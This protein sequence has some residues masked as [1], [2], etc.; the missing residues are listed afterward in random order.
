MRRAGD[1][2]QAPTGWI[3]RSAPRVED[4]RLLRGEGR[5]VDDLA[6]AGGLHLDFTRSAQAGLALA[7]LDIEEARA[8]PGV[9]AILTA[10][11]LGELPS[12]SVNALL[13]GLAAPRFEALAATTL[14]YVGQPVAAVVADS[15][16][17]AREAAQSVRILAGAPTPPDDGPVFSH[18]IIAGDVEPAFAAAAHVARASTR[19]ARLAPA[20]LEPRAALA[21]WCEA[22]GLT[23]HVAT[24]TPHRL[25]AELA[26]VLQMDESRLRVVAP[27]VGGAFGGRASLHPE[28]IVVAFAARALG[29][30]VKWRAARGD[31]FLAATQGRGGTLAGEL[32]LDAHGR[33]LALRATIDMPLGAW[34]VYSAAAPGRNAQRILPGPYA[35]AAV[36][37]ALAGRLA[38]TAAVGIYRGAGRPEAALLMERLMDEAARLAGLDP[39]EIRRRNLPPAHDAP[40]RAPTGVEIDSSDLPALLDHAARRFDYAGARR[41]VAARRA[42]GEL[43][44]LG[45]GLYVEPCGQGWECATARLQD[46]GRILAGTGSS[47]QGQGRETAAAQILADAMGVAMQRVEVRH[48]DTDATPQGIGALASRSTAIGGA[49]LWRAGR[50]LREAAA[51]A[52]ASRLRVP[53]AALTATPDGFRAADGRAI[54]WTELAA[55][56]APGLAVEVTHHAEQEAWASG[57]AMALVTIDR[58]TGAPT[59]ERLTLVD[60]AGVV[61]NPA[62]AEGQLRGGVMQGVGE[63]LMERLVYDEAGQLLTGSLMDYALPRAADAPPLDL[64]SRA[65]PAPGNPLGAKGVGEAGCIGA[66]AAIVGAIHDALGPLGGAR[67]DMPLTSGRIWAAMRAAASAPQEEHR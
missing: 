21:Q 59:I 61:I 39:I 52:A 63:A 65:T 11:D 18:R 47:A 30:P 66:P 45:V 44:G 53:Q 41:A 24:Q 36:D 20:P 27:D 64:D 60:D 17:A 56:S 1:E 9:V 14:A 5:F 32:A 37:I 40:R 43:C 13:P 28:E 3:G 54:D 51:R 29:R 57:C 2:A 6:P 4:E 67:L 58:D 31:D 62:L 10:A 25:R 15:A 49:A 22:D 48:G 42:A 35:V 50:A 46:D 38:P 34:L 16:E 8:M 33:A 7:G 12:P 23:L 55:A 19:H 26:R